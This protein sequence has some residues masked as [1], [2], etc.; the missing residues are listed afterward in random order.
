MTYVYIN[1]YMCMRIHMCV[2]VHAVTVIDNFISLF[3]R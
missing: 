1:I 2:C 3:V